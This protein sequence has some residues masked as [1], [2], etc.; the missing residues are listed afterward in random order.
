[1]VVQVVSKDQLPLGYVISDYFIPYNVILSLCKNL[2]KVDKT[3]LGIE[4]KGSIV[5]VDSIF[6]ICNDYLI[7][8]YNLRF[9]FDIRDIC[10]L[11]RKPDLNDLSNL[12]SFWKSC[13][14]VSSYTYTV[15]DKYLNVLGFIM[16]DT[17]IK[18]GGTCYICMF[19]IISKGNK[20]GSRVINELLKSVSLKGYSCVTA[21]PFWRS[22]SAN[23]SDDF[24][25]KI[26]QH[27]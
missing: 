3:V 14:V 19:E 23:F 17:R 16:T 1:M 27:I 5:T 21:I 25:F 6:P 9:E 4:V 7:I 15:V 2:P 12:S 11:E 10:F 22:M 24:H 13:D 26:S 18:Y 20:V 8:L